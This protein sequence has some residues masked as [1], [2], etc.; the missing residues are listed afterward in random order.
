VNIASNNA[1]VTCGGRLFQKLSPET[2]KARLLTVERLNSGTASSLEAA[3]QIL[4][5]DGTS[6]TRVKYDDS[7]QSINQSINQSIRFFNVAKTAIAITKS[8]VT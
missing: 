8:T 5:G 2:G 4:C 3:D 6:V 1:D 7:Y